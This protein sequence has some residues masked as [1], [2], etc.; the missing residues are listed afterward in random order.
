VVVAV[1][2]KG[3]GTP[4]RSATVAVVASNKFVLLWAEMGRSAC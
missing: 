4:A 3:A 2:V 1:A